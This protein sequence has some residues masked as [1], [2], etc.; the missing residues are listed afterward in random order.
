M[1]IADRIDAGMVVPIVAAAG[2]TGNVTGAAFEKD[3][4]FS[5]F[6]AIVETSSGNG[7]ATV[8]IQCSNDGVNW[9]A[10]PMGIIT[11]SGASGSSDGFTT[12]AP[13]KKVRA[14]LS[15]VTGIGVKVKVL[16]GY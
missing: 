3:S 14:V 1:A 11:V 5:S 9:C 10:T 2:E 12:Q 7:T 6:Q 8:T 16:M 15:N 4:V 13:W